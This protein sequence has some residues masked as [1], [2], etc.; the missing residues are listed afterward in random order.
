MPH[1]FMRAHE[2]DG[3]G[4]SWEKYPRFSFIHDNDEIASSWCLVH[5]IR[6]WTKNYCCWVIFYFCSF[7]FHLCAQ[8]HVAAVRG[9][10]ARYSSSPWNHA[11]N[12]INV[13]APITS[14][15]FMYLEPCVRMTIVMM[16]MMVTLIDAFV[17]Q[18]CV[19]SL[20][21]HWH[22]LLLKYDCIKI[23]NT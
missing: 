21:R 6:V 16:M 19:Y 15:M 23:Y 22:C 12:T 18:I 5:L 20:F 3:R 14:F 13:I 11:D 1:S 7:W 17:L 9:H 2:I 10:T 8:R 4:K